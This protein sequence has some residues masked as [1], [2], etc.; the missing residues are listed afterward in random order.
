MLGR[1]AVFMEQARRD[2][3]THER[4]YVKKGNVIRDLEDIET[5]GLMPLL[6]SVKLAMEAHGGH[7]TCGYVTRDVMSEN[8]RNVPTRH[9]RYQRDYVVLYKFKMTM[10]SLSRLFLYLSN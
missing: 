4:L 8:I 9:M 2:E 1:I 3:S 6:C 5:N 7:V 10:E